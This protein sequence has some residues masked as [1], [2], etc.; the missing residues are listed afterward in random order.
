MRLKRCFT[1]AIYKE[2]SNPNANR[3]R[4]LVIELAVVFAVAAPISVLLLLPNYTFHFERVSVNY[5]TNGSV[6]FTANVSSLVNALGAIAMLSLIFGLVI[7]ATIGLTSSVYF[8]AGA[9]AG[10]LGEYEYALEEAG[11]VKI[12]RR[13]DATTYQLTDRGR[14]FLMEYK[15]LAGESGEV[16]SPPIKKSS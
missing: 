9:A 15:F 12:E 7:G 1:S 11:F 5:Y 6:D 2:A 3:R 13:A 10:K 4:L 8:K 16:T 14:R